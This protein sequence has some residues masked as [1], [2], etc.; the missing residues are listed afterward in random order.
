[1]K[2]PLLAWNKNPGLISNSNS[3]SEKSSLFYCCLLN[4]KNSDIL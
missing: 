2:A 4:K 1:M 3:K